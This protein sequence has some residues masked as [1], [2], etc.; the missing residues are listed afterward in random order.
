M[1]PAFGQQVEEFH[2]AS[3][4]ILKPRRPECVEYGNLVI[5][6]VLKDF[7]RRQT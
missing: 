5:K 3:R 4:G 1:T 6:P 2:L 7:P